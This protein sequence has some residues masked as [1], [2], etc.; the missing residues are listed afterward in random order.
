VEAE[1]DKE[2]KYSEIIDKYSTYLISAKFKDRGFSNKYNLGDGFGKE[3]SPFYNGEFMLALV[4][5]YEYSQ[6]EKVEVILEET[7]DYLSAKEEYET[8]LYLWIMAALKDMNRLWPHEKYV[9]YAKDFTAWRIDLSLMKHSTNS[10]YCAPLEGMTSAYSILE[11]NVNYELLSRL[12]SEINFWQ[13]KTTY[14]QL[15]KNSP[16]RLMNLDGQLQLL[17]Q[18]NPNLSHGGFLSAENIPLQRIDFTQ[19]CVSS[20]LQKLVDINGETF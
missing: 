20:Y 19:H 5:Y 17:K 18:T 4:K 15:N 2:A 1:P 6:D 11:N 8:P 3:E 12:S 13:N 9:K 14:L 10:N 7:F 16:Y